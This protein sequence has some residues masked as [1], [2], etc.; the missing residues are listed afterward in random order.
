MYSKVLSGTVL[1]LAGVRVQVETDISDG[2]PMLTMVGYLSSCV[3]EAG[4]RV[5]TALK[6]SG[7]SLPPKR[8]TINLSPADIRK[9]GTG[10]DLPI[11][12]GILSAMG[13]IP[14]DRLEDTLIVGE[15]SLDGAVNPINGILPLVHFAGN[16]GIKRCIVPYENA[17][18]AALISAI[19]VIPVKNINELADYMNGALEISPVKADVESLF[20]QEMEYDCDFSDVIGQEVLKRGV[21]IA[22]AGLHNILMTGAAGAGKSM[23]AKR[24]PTIL[25]G[26]T[27]DESLE[28]TKIY[29]VAGMLGDGRSL[30]ATRPF[31]SPHHTIS[32][33]AL[34]GGGAP[35]RPGE[36]S[37][38]HNGVLFLDEL[39]EFPRNVLETLRQPL[40]DRE[41]HISRI[42]N[43]YTFP[44]DF[45]LVAARNACPCGHYPDM[46]KC[47]CSYGMIRK[48]QMKVS[49]PLLD[50]ID[51]YVEAMPVKA[52]SLFQER[53]S[54]SSET[55]RERVADARKLQA[56]RYKNERINYNS[57]LQGGMT[58]RYIRISKGDEDFARAA[59]ESME[60]SMRGWQRL[61]KVSRTIA[62]LAGDSEI[63]EEHL[64]EAVFFRERREV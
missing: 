21:E 56:I 57:Q 26:L 51:I 54:E 53:V 25:P 9:D 5:R 63:R 19:E 48:Y 55:I 35:I 2:L 16:E 49:G 64:K 13:I 59:F 42:N 24:I 32:Q 33:A 45:M 40:E 20:R 44:A 22:A 41:I 46:S 28:I 6:N 39:P 23:I 30:I 14:T 12:A 43:T 47:T 38:S 15:L 58:D 60:L 62:D 11:A 17:N 7:Y 52:D 61:L 18:E 4:E 29:S 36:I 50:R 31:R 27:F 1:G 10:F 8:I 34:S 37:L 3:R